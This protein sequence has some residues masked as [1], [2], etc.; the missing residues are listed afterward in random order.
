MA[1]NDAHYLLQGYQASGAI[2]LV[3]ELRRYNN[4]YQVRAA[5]ADNGSGGNATAWV[6]IS[7]AA[8]YLEID[9]QAA[10]SG[11]ITLW[12]DGVQQGTAAVNNSARRVDSVRLGAVDGVDT[13]T[14]GTTYFDAFESRR[15]SY[16]GPQGWLR[17]VRAML[18]AA[19]AQPTER[20]DY[21][22]TTVIDYAYDP[23]GRLRVASYNTG[24]RFEYTYDAVGNRLTAS[25]PLSVTSYQYDAANRLVNV[26]GVAYTWDDNGN[27]LSD[28]VYTY[29]YDHA[30]RLVSV[31]SN[32]SSVT[33]YQYNGQGDRLSQTVDGVTTNYTLDLNSG[34]TQVLADGTN[35]YLYGRS[36]LAEYSAAGTAYDL[37][38]A[39][40]SVR[41]LADAAGQVTLARAYRPYGE[42]L[43]SNGAGATS[44]G[45]TGEATDV[46]GMVYLRARYYAPGVGRF[47]SRDMWAGDAKMPM[48]Y[49][50]WLY[51]YGDPVN[52]TDPSGFMPER[53]NYLASSYFSP[54]P[55]STSLG[56]LIPDFPV[57]ILD[58]CPLPGGPEDEAEAARLRQEIEAKYGLI[59]TGHTYNGKTG[60]WSVDDLLV[61][62]DV[63]SRIAYRF[64]SVVNWYEVAAIYRGLRVDISASELFRMAFG[65]LEIQRGDSDTVYVP[66]HGNVYGWLKSKDCYI[67]YGP[68]SHW[69]P[70]SRRGVALLL[71]EFGHVLDFRNG[72]QHATA[73]GYEPSLQPLIEFIEYREEKTG[74]AD[75]G[76][77]RLSGLGVNF[78]TELNVGEY[79]ADLFASWVL[80]DFDTNANMNTTGPLS[81]PEENPDC[82]RKDANDGRVWKNYID[83]YMINVAT[84]LALQWMSDNGY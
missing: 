32:Q 1:A 30:N 40:G 56:S 72:Q 58:E 3:V 31:T 19:M 57:S 38:D 69:E 43:S 61:L 48:S 52:Y 66:D 42:T 78:R 34:L 41:Q 17:K 35:T 14:R 50:G 24:D 21:P 23:L 26:N 71:H 2:V 63:V 83:P 13:G 29:G 10:V 12:V 73:L 74:V 5:L 6:T 28:G 67:A 15:T 53:S 62:E 4:T 59:L 20:L 46:T 33:S 51:T 68:K 49:N 9:W 11:G 7:D 39:L 18:L 76:I 77:K 22:T 80:N 47:I 44:Y 84:D 64:K 45:F 82:N 65:G 36:R 55:P 81:C 16:I 8:H 27:L 54:K 75:K 70:G 79:W 25:D 60:K 37:A